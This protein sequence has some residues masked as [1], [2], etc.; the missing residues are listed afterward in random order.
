MYP[1]S[2]LVLLALG[3]NVHGHKGMPVETLRWAVNE[4]TRLGFSPI[5]TSSAWSCAPYGRLVQPRFVNAVILV[6]AI[7][8]PREVLRMLQSLENRAGRRRGR[9]W[10]PRALDVDVLDLAGMCRRPPGMGRRATG[11]AAHAWQRRG[12][13]LPHPGIAERPFVLLPLVEIWPDWRH[14]LLG[15]TARQLLHALPARLQRSCRRLPDVGLVE[16]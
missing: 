16:G 11:A 6:R 4:L 7:R 5:H 1:T 9:A 12:L 15:C 14:P 3:A 8:P 2:G 13:V 10:G